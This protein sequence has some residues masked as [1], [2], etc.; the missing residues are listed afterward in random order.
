[1]IKLVNNKKQ[2][3]GKTPNIPSAYLACFFANYSFSLI[4]VNPTSR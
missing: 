2:G 4:L 1:M 3:H